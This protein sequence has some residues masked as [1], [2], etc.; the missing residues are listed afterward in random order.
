I[1]NAWISL[2]KGRTADLAMD[3]ITAAEL[4]S[5]ETAG[6][7]GEV[8]YH[9]PTLLSHFRTQVVSMSQAQTLA[10]NVYDT[11]SDLGRAEANAGK[12]PLPVDVLRTFMYTGELQSNYLAH[13]APDPGQLAAYSEEINTALAGAAA[14]SSGSFTL[15]VRAD[16]FDAACPVL[17]TGGSV[18]KS[19]YT[20]SGN[21]FR[22]P[23]TFT[24]QPGAEIS[25]E[26]YTDVTWDQCPGTDPLE[27]ISLALTAVPVASGTDADGNLIPD[28]YE[29]M[30]LAGSGGLATSDLDGDGFSDLQEYLDGTDPDNVTSYGSTPVDFSAP[31]IWLDASDLSIGWPA[32]YADAFVFTV[33]YTGDLAGTPFAEDQE[34]PGGALDAT[35][36]LS[37]DQRFYRVKMR[38]R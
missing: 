9:L 14:R 28:D 30:F 6:P 13:I 7:G 4:Q 37:A 18:A 8:A 11:C 33:E 35:L 31:F 1:S 36:D 5:L 12:Y 22:F 24:L 17:Y 25:V 10:I 34:L 23:T 3:G 19:L 15:E 2:F 27:I 26:A 29:E 38:L 21:P 16:S 20:A 32:A